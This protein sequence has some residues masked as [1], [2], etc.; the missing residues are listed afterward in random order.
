MYLSINWTKKWLKIPKDIS[1]KQIGED[2]TMSTVEVEEVIDQAKDLENVVVARIDEITKHPQADR[3][4]VCEVTIDKNQK[5]T[6]VCGGTNLTKGMLV[7]VAKVGSRVKWHGEGELITLEK[8]KIR[9]VESNGMIAASEEIGLGD[10]FPQSSDKDILDLSHLDLKVGEN[11]AVALGLDDVIID[12]DNKSINH[13]PDLWG[14][15]GLAREL[16]AIYKLKLGEYT[17]TEWKST[18]KEKLKVKVEDVDNCF[19]YMGLMIDGVKVAESPWWLKKSLEAVGIRPINNIVDVT[20]YVMYELGQP[21][22]AFDAKQIANN[23]IIVKKASAGEEFVTLDGEKRKLNKETLMIAD[24]KKNIAIAGIMGGQNTEIDIDTEKI[25]LESANFKDSSIRRSSTQLGLRS[26]S[27]SR[28]EKSLDPV[29]AEKAIKKAAA[30]ILELCPEATITSDLV[31]INNN[32]FK[33]VNFTVSEDLINKR[34]GQIIPTKEIKDILQRL[35]FVVTYKAKVFS[36]KVPSFRATKD[37][38]IAEDIVEEVAR[39]YGYDNLDYSLPSVVLKKPILNIGKKAEKDIKKWLSWSQGYNEVYTYPFTNKAWA[40]K[41]DLKYE[42]HIKMVN[43]VSPEQSLLNLS[44]L[45]NLFAV[46][47]SNVRWYNNFKIFELQRVFDKSQKGVFSVDK[48][49]NNFLPRQDKFLSGLELTPKDAQKVFLSVKGFVSSMMKH[50]NIEWSEESLDLKYA[51]TAYQIKHQDIVLGYYG[52]LNKGL[53]D[54]GGSKLEVAFWNFDFTLLTKYINY[55]NEYKALAK[56]PDVKRDMAIILDNNIQWKDLE[57]E[58]YKASS[59]I[60]KVELFDTFVG[61]EIGENKKSIAF[62]LEFRSDDRTLI[63]EDVDDLMD[64]IFDVLSKKFEAV[65]R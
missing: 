59:L 25:I 16:A 8:V 11:L 35:E 14:Q 41:I 28:F 31:D 53:F 34:F 36:I 26:E 56:F 3:L 21:M 60:R 24:S 32:P 2:L 55:A 19:R 64:K 12:I 39:I 57:H 48:K 22:H 6:I 29:L 61:P 52:L 43:A 1:S 45:P 13:R 38:S 37:I 62:H 47:E 33:E 54:D 58:I 50:W 27:S 51:K 9:G 65:L 40:K 17:L 23:T 4:Q 44:L 49:K 30:M 20:N 10:L 5:E 63:A 15:Y 18:K 46:A 7:A 42:D